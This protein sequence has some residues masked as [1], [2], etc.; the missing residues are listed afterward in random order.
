MV[1]G[2]FDTFLF[3]NF[4]LGCKV[5]LIF[6]PR[7]RSDLYWIRIIGAKLNEPALIGMLAPARAYS[8]V[9]ED[10]RVEY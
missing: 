10:E 9:W 7:N 2:Y 5:F 8:A 6:F 3:S 1:T 4:D